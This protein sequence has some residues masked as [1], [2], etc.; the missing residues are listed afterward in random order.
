MCQC[1]AYWHNF[2]L[3]F[4]FFFIFMDGTDFFMDKSVIS[5]ENDVN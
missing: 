5:F 3:F 1:N 2:V 4:L